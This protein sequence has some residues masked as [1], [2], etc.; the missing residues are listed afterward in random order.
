MQL[1]TVQYLM[2]QEVLKETLAALVPLRV[3]TSRLASSSSESA[4]K[5]KNQN[6]KTV[7]I[8]SNYVP[9]LS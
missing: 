8:C 6:V 9:L 4:Q 3:D 2:L 7:R 5:E 1:N